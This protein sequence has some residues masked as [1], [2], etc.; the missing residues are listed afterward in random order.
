[1]QAT[2]V[3]HTSKVKFTS[4]HIFQKKINKQYPNLGC[5]N[6][7]PQMGW[8]QQQTF[9]SHNSGVLVSV[10]KPL[11]GLQTAVFFLQP[12][13][14]KKRRLWSLLLLISVLIPSLGLHPHDLIKLPPKAPLP[15]TITLEV[16]ASVCEFGETQT[17]SPQLQVKLI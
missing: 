1:M 16:R 10:E 11:P 3:S 15:S 17:F 4:S 2:N 7:I 9:I 6:K 12:Y 14:V 5:H 13:V 8:F